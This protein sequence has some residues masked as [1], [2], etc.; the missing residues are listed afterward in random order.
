[1]TDDRRSGAGG[2]AS[3]E[4]CQEGL[5]DFRNDVRLRRY[6]VV[7]RWFRRSLGLRWITFCILSRKGVSEWRGRR[8]F[9]A[10]RLPV[11]LSRTVM[12]R[13]LRTLGLLLPWHLLTQALSATVAA[14]GVWASDRW[15][16]AVLV[17]G[18]DGPIFIWSVVVQPRFR[19]LR[20]PSDD[21]SR[22]VRRSL[23]GLNGILGSV[24]FVFVIMAF[25]LHREEIHLLT[26]GVCVGLMAPLLLCAPVRGAVEIMVIPV[27][28][29]LFGAVIEGSFHRS[30]LL[31][32]SF[33][34]E[35]MACGLFVVGASRL[36]EGLL[37]RT[38]IVRLRQREK[39]D[40]LSLLT[41]C[42]VPQGGGWLWET[43]ETGLLRNPSIGL[44]RALGQEETQIAG[45]TIH[46]LVGLSDL[47]PETALP[48]SG[49]LSP[50]Y[51][52]RHS[53]GH[54]LAFRDLTVRV[55][56]SDRWWKLTGQP[57]FRDGA[58]LG[59]R[60]VGTDV[61]AMQGL[62]E[63]HFHRVRIDDLTGLPNRLACLELLQN[64]L[65][66]MTQG[67][68]VFVMV[69]VSLEGT[70]TGEFRKFL[71]EE[72]ACAVWESV[73]RVRGLVG[74]IV[75]DEPFIA[76]YGPMDLAFA[77]DVPSER[78]YSDLETM[79]LN[80]LS[81]LD[82]PI[83]L[84][85]GSEIVLEAA[86]GIA[87]ACSEDGDALVEA[88]ETALGD[89]RGERVG[90]Y[91]IFDSSDDLADIRRKSLFRD[92]REA[93][94]LKAFML[95]YQPIVNVRTGAVIGFEALCRWKGAAYGHLSIEKVIDVIMETGHG[96][97]FD[98]WVLETACR[99]AQRW[100]E[101]LWVSV[102]MT[103]THFSLP[104]IAE[105]IFAVVERTGLEPMR[106]QLELT[107]T[108]ALEAGSQTCQAFRK[109][110]GKGIRIALDDF[111][112]GYSSLMYLRQFPF[113]KIKLDAAFI[114]DMLQDTRS[115]AVVRN[116]IEL[117][118]DLGI[119]VTAEGISSPEHYRHLREQGC[120]E[121]QGFFLGRPV[122]EEDVPLCW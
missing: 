98:F 18:I 20:L 55:A 63:Q 111:G 120:T 42:S 35:V 71:P 52:L 102:N 53:L 82:R 38:Q 87:V 112:K 60:G 113:S 85:S 78:K 46:A 61:T 114:Q 76:R 36:V 74:R 22:F 70:R 5:A 45:R 110:E 27:V 119:G 121:A 89:A 56:K 43:D 80:I 69:L 65:L 33:I 49:G 7:R 68:R 90:R 32:M 79:A 95:V 50:A 101:D 84:P 13:H 3:G 31:T 108:C 39:L 72:Q 116:V 86:V 77:V 106:L 57:L 1:M 4:E 73:S 75:S 122:L 64:R 23:R 41:R 97:E 105:R 93:L 66:D 40:I 54:Q 28:A 100:R 115:A 29:G 59:Y 11:H 92:V 51:R 30:M 9:S 21:E 104:D 47:S 16:A 10:S 91:S 88:A 109:L 48:S 107:E 15:L 6:G 37:W 103:A 96:L 26:I 62:S 67:H 117:A 12:V 34:F 83:F 2:S 44:C 8:A 94:R 19:K 81:E 24:W 17:L 14:L 58:F 99:T 118:M 25:R